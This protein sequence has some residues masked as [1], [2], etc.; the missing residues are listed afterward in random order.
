M[1]D[2][3]G[4]P[5]V[6]KNMKNVERQLAD[7]RPLK[8]VIYMQERRRSPQRSTNKVHHDRFNRIKDLVIIEP[9]KSLSFKSFWTRQGS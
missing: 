1:S 8:N 9:L 4:P 5:Q 3:K 6:D 7:K 2:E